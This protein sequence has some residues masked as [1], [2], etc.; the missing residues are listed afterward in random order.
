VRGPGA[1]V[2]S[3][4]G[5]PKGIVPHSNLMMAN[6]DGSSTPSNRSNPQCPACQPPLIDH[7][8]AQVMGGHG[9]TPGE[10]TVTPIYWAPPGYSFS[11]SYKAIINGYLDDVAAAS[12]STSNVYAMM[13]EYYQQLGTNPRQQIQYLV[14]AGTE[15]DATESFPAQDSFGCT[16]D[17]GYSA[18]VDDSGLLVELRTL[19]AAHTLHEDDAH[20]YVVLLPPGVESCFGSGAASGTN[21]CSTNTY[22]AYHNASDE[23]PTPNILIWA[24]LPYPDLSAC[25]DVVDGP[26]APNGDAYADATV[27]LISHEAIEAITDTWGA[28]YDDNGFEMA[29]ECSY[30]Y[31][32]PLGSTGVTTG[33][34]AT[35]TYYNQVINGRRYYTQ[36]EFTNEQ[37]LYDVGDDPDALTT[38]RVAGCLQRPWVYLQPT[39]TS[40]SVHAG[41]QA[42]G[43][44][45]SITGTHFTGIRGIKFGDT[46][47]D[48]GGSSSD[49]DIEAKVPPHAAGTVDVTIVVPGSTSDPVPADR[50]TYARAGSA[51]YVDTAYEDLL[52][53]M[54]TS[55]RFAYWTSYLDH[56][57][58]HTTFVSSLTTSAEH[59]AFTITGLYHTILG[60]TPSASSVANWQTQVTSGKKT[61]A[62][63][64]VAFYAS[65]EF[66]THAGA[67][68]T[69]GWV[70]AL[71]HHIL[72]RS[73][74]PASL[75][76]WVGRTSSAGRTTVARELYQS[77]ESRDD[78]VVALYEHM[79][80]RPPDKSNETAWAT[81]ILTH[82]DDS[83]MQHLAT[84]STYLDASIVRY[85]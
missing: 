65:S 49:T 1:A 28:L 80:L 85:P 52:G 7:V 76:Y 8:D 30:V 15:V 21:P 78:R 66:F 43:N 38:G 75:A 25:A 2:A 31:G 17:V 33:P 83:L 62:D 3:A 82:G 47:S 19:A 27:S 41:P 73:P 81:T 59:V 74:G 79:I 18:C 67:G 35:G 69:T 64:A 16:A 54:P 60:R 29:D 34:G 53:R 23:F 46:W 50:Y 40:I 63:V 44:Y 84:S 42:G 55:S 72:N 51:P 45:I 9:A 14:H 32:K 20:L 22:C 12:G 26:Q 39:I 58:S 56:G 71:Y 4:T 11:D 70:N 57:G 48:T 6:L 5:K 10:A 13:T 61:T 77:T 36:D 24:A 68:S 37:S